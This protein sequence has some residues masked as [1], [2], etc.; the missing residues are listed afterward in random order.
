MTR[1]GEPLDTQVAVIGAGPVGLM[2]AGEL[3]EAG[4][5]VTIVER[6]PAPMRES[7][8]SQLTTRTAEILHARGLDDLLAEARPEPRAHFGGLTF[9]LSTVN[10]PYAGNWKVP[11]HRTEA[12]LARRARRLGA[13][14]LRG[15]ELT[16]LT[17]T[18]RHVRLQI[19]GPAGRRTFRAEYV[20]GCDGEDSTVRALGGFEFAGAAATREML[21][22]DVTGV[23]IPDRRFERLEHG[24]AVAATRDGVTRVMVHAYGQA[25]VRRTGP[26]AF[27]EVADTWAKVTGE[28]ISTGRAVWTDAFG[29]ARGQVTRYRR[30]RVLLAGDA[31]HRHLPIGG[32]S[33]NVG[34]QDAVNLGWRLAGRVHGWADDD[35]L[36]GYHTERHPVGARV[37]RA[38]TAQ[39][40]LLFG[41]PEV[42]PLRTVLAEL[43]AY[44]QARDHLAALVSGL[45]I[46]YGTGHHRLVGRRMPDITL[47]TGTRTVSTARLPVHG[48]GVLLTLPGSP[49]TRTH[50]ETLIP[51]WASRI[52]VVHATPTNDAEGLEVL[53]PGRGPRVGVVHGAPGGDAEGLEGLHTVLVRPDG[54][55]AWVNGED[56]DLEGAL[57]R[58]FG[59]PSVR[60]ARRPGRS[61]V[62]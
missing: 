59:A 51:G 4:V 2:L 36:D 43:L 27:T 25:P 26:P 45:D 15:Y 56:D 23:R 11:Q 60:A 21:R 20:V 40:I 58:W 55:V 16:G 33:I 61:A 57:R 17:D 32:Q 42:T 49:F 24:L 48:R 7:R 9:D 14:L 10:S 12:A 28:D 39:E 18:D 1:T 41:G 8:A 19:D 29:N 52:D 47:R 3:R 30:G 35:L 46:R 38:V 54:Y 31:A 44:G 5:S 13:Q 34:L 37:L 62:G 22:A 53:V 50:L 6:L